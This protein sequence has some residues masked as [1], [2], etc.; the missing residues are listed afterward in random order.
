[1]AKIEHARALRYCSRGMR[2][3]FEHHG[4]DYL[5]F[6]REGY[7]VEVLEA[8]GDQMALDVAKVAREQERGA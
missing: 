7:P 5:T 1:M 8:T 2:A 3:F 4:L 6:V